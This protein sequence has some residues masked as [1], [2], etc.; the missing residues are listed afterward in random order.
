MFRRLGLGSTVEIA[1]SDLASPQHCGDVPLM[2]MSVRF[3][4]MENSPVLSFGFRI[5]AC[6]YIIRTEACR[7]HH[8]GSH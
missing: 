6:A 2:M 1:G 5:E 8:M 3:K 7:H 4:E